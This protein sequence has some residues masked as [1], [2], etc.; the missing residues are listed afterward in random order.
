MLSP[1]T[2]ETLND[3]IENRL[4][5]MGVS[6]QDDLREK[7]NLQRALTELQGNFMPAGVLQGFADA[8][9]RGRRRKIGDA[10]TR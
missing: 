5:C 1:R 2:I 4:A 3:L 8:P 7:M 10:A 9:R 6:D